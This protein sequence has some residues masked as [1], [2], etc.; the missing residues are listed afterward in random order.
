MGQGKE[1]PLYGVKDICRC[2]LTVTSKTCILKP[3]QIL[4]SLIDLSPLFQISATNPQGWPLNLNAYTLILFLLLPFCFNALTTCEFSLDSL[5]D[6]RHFKKKATRK[7]FSNMI[8][9]KEKCSKLRRKWIHNVICNYFMQ[10]IWVEPKWRNR[11]LECR[12]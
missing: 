3:S 8:N 7:N 10:G 9:N 2:Q 4:F 1:M 12:K 5:L 11:K 6:H